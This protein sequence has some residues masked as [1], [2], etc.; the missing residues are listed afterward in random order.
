MAEK[1]EGDEK[2]S[3]SPAKQKPRV[4]E[5]I[6]VVTLGEQP[7]SPR[8]AREDMAHQPDALVADNGPP[9]LRPID[10]G[11]VDYDL[12]PPASLLSNEAFQRVSRRGRS[13]GASIH[14]QD[15]A[16]R[17]PSGTVSES[18]HSTP[19]TTPQQ[20]TPA[21]GHPL[22]LPPPAKEEQQ[23][24]PAVQQLKSEPEEM[25][26]AVIS[27]DDE[28]TLRRRPTERVPAS[29]APPSKQYLL[30]TVPRRHTVPDQLEDGDWLSEL[31]RITAGELPDPKPKKA[32]K[33]KKSKPQGKL[34]GSMKKRFLKLSLS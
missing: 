19:A 5:T 6:F 22:A 27:S 21:T 10:D 14:V 16:R 7:N 24:P 20:S 11:H 3:D 13:R 17:P 18:R 25:E 29:Y 34:L 9:P 12:T 2:R 30:S 8:V 26:I 28:V 15:P 23:G 1:R 33:P 4:E 31:V 32:G